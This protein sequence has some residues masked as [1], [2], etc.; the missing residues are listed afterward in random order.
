MSASAPSFA[1]VKRSCRKYAS[2][3]ES[4]D[5]LQAENKYVNTTHF[6]APHCHCLASRA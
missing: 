2:Q 4:G 3:Y 1:K 6:P 5:C